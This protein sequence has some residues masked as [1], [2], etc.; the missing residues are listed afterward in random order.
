MK[1]IWDAHDRTEG[2]KKMPDRVWAFFYA[3]SWALWPWSL[4]K[5]IEE[6]TLSEMHA[7][8][9]I[10]WKSEQGYIDSL[11]D[12]MSGTR[13]HMRAHC[14]YWD[15]WKSG[16]LHNPCGVSETMYTAMVYLWADNDKVDR[17]DVL[18]MTKISEHAWMMMLQEEQA[19]PR[20]KQMVLSVQPLLTFHNNVMKLFEIR[21][22]VMGAYRAD[23]DNLLD[24]VDGNSGKCSAAFVYAI[25]ATEALLQKTCNVNKSDVPS[26]LWEYITCS[27]RV[28]WHITKMDGYAMDT[29]EEFSKRD[30]FWH[31]LDAYNVATLAFILSKQHERDTSDPCEW[32]MELRKDMQER[33]APPK[34]TP[35][36]KKWK[37]PEWE[38]TWIINTPENVMKLVFL[39]IKERGRVPSLR[40]CSNCE[41]LANT[42]VCEGC[43]IHEDTCEV[44]VYNEPS[45]WNR[46][47]LWKPMARYCSKKCQREDWDSH[48]HVCPR[49]DIACEDLEE[50]YE[51]KNRRTKGGYFWIRKCCAHTL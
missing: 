29:M 23:A 27:L 14:D 12:L 3:E 1:E 40:I 9:R 15:N 43:W 28:A 35:K 5:S 8:F 2:R 22:R 39:Q 31:F 4:T 50:H 38:S 41:V 16:L 25:F 49:Y 20:E 21:R 30:T 37:R 48:Q 42:K 13:D 47:V 26:F 10:R 33:H 24:Y 36:K 17:L 18:R 11:F 44:C 19:L 6:T 32:W 45:D 51:E 46:K 7:E 34:P